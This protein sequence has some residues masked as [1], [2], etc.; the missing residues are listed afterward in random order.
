MKGSKIEGNQLTIDIAEGI[1]SANKKDVRI[2]NDFKIKDS[3]P[4]EVNEKS[5]T[6]SVILH[7]V[8]AH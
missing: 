8:L 1:I 5:R 2:D 7:K 4:I 3:A 6:V